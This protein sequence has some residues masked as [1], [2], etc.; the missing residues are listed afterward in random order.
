M[1]DLLF[2]LIIFGLITSGVACLMFGI[3]Y[4]L[5]RKCHNIQHSPGNCYL[6][7]IPLGVYFGGLIIFCLS[8]IGLLITHL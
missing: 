5:E 4:M 2:I 6:G 7:R 8:I 1:N 3:G